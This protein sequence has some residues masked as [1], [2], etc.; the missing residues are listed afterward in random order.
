MQTEPLTEYRGDGP[1]R[2]PSLPIRD[3]VVRRSIFA[4][5]P[6]HRDPALA[7]D[8]LRPA[9]RDGAR[10]DVDGLPQRLQR[11]FLQPFALRRMGV[12]R[13]GDVLQPRAHL[14]RQAE[15]RRQF[16]HPCADRLDAEHQMIVGARDDADEAVLV[17]VSSRGR[18]PGTGMRR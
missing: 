6:Q 3:P 13:A 12:D 4:A 10:S 7:N 2:R 18:W 17:R 5:L 14:E 15:R 16:R 9:R 11:R 8:A 1:H